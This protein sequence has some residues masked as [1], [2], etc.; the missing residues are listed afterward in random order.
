M[1]QPHILCKPRL[2]LL[3]SLLGDGRISFPLPVNFY[4]FYLDPETTS[5]L[6]A[7]KKHFFSAKTLRLQALDGQNS[8]Q[9]RGLSPDRGRI[10]VKNWCAWQQWVICSLGEGLALCFL[11]YCFI[12]IASLS[13]PTGFLCVDFWCMCK[14]SNLGSVL[15]DQNHSTQAVCAPGSCVIKGW[16]LC[17]LFSALPLFH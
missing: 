9:V 15:K 11:L 13:P 16:L 7:L 17:S 4:L 10:I 5:P 6:Q 8:L 3:S 2:K 14:A 1:F 12:L